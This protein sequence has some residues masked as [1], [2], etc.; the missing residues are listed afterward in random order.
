MPGKIKGGKIKGTTLWGPLEDRPAETDFVTLPRSV[1]Y[2]KGYLH[3]SVPR[4]KQPLPKPFKHR[5]V[6]NPT[7]Q[8]VTDF[9]PPIRASAYNKGYLKSSG[10]RV[11]YPLGDG[12]MTEE[13]AI[14]RLDAA[15]GTA[16]DTRQSVPEIARLEAVKYNPADVLEILKLLAKGDLSDEQL[17][18]Y[19]QDRGRLRAYAAVA[20]TRALTAAE[21]EVVNEIGG[22]LTLEVKALVAEDV[23]LQN[24]PR[25]LTREVADLD[26]ARLAAVALAQAEEIKRIDAEAGAKNMGAAIVPIVGEAKALESP[27]DLLEDEVKRNILR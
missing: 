1:T 26:S 18:A 5:S 20:K 16:P 27:I 7:D 12:P 11:K 21:Q 22:R 8:A 19:E 6:H 17:D 10:P 13:K 3:S 23:A 25:T 9:P 15:D 14:E 24:E 2:N 4:Y